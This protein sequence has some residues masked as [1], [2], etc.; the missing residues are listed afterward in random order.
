MALADADIK[1]AA[2]AALYA[3]ATGAEHLVASVE[4][5]REKRPS[6]AP[7]AQGIFQDPLPVR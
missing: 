5:A 6:L 7:A 1:V 3:V 4:K 2:L